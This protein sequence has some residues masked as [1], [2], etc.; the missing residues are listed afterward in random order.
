LYASAQSSKNGVQK[1]CRVFLLFASLLFGRRQRACR[2]RNPLPWRVVSCW[3]GEL[4]KLQG[5]FQV[6]GPEGTGGHVVTYGYVEGP[7]TLGGARPP[8]RLTAQLLPLLT[9][10]GNGGER[11]DGFSQVPSRQ[12]SGGS[13][14]VTPA[15]APA[16]NS[17]LPICL[18][19]HPCQ[20]TYRILRRMPAPTTNRTVHSP[21][22]V[23]SRL[24]VERANVVSSNS[25][26]LLPSLRLPPTRSRI[27]DFR[28]ETYD[29]QTTLT[30]PKPA[31]L[32]SFV[33]KERPRDTQ[34]AGTAHERLRYLSCVSDSPPAPP[35]AP[36]QAVSL[37]RATPWYSDNFNFV[38]NGN[39]PCRFYV[40]GRRARRA[41]KLQ[42]SVQIIG[43]G[44]VS[45]SFLFFSFRF[46]N[47][48]FFGIQAFGSHRTLA[49]VVKMGWH[50]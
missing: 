3:S 18:Y 35:P 1:A 10:G 21:L 42:F 22:L 9:L 25:E 24:P 33:K 30:V 40:R 4:P 13:V 6:D 7:T 32:F 14:V 15:T 5:T 46:F 8:R 31:S 17:E 44:F 2:W 37:A 38:E 45:L 12:K 27:A 11:V 26:T 48:Q 47:T 43:V 41:A 20:N 36:F 39:A 49:G 16:P 28:L 19:T 50:R 29:N 34:N 23:N